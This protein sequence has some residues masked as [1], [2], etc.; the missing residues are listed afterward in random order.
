MAIIE[1]AVE[2]EEDLVVVDE[3]GDD[4][5]FRPFGLGVEFFSEAVPTGFIGER[6]FGEVVVQDGLMEMDNELEE[7]GLD[8]RMCEIICR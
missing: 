2:D 4:L 5:C 8:E 3:R 7:N 6:D 1:L